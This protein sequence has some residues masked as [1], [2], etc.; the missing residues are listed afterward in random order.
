MHGRHDRLPGI[1]IYLVVFF[2]VDFRERTVVVD[3]SVPPLTVSQIIDRDGLEVADASVELDYRHVSATAA[4]R[5]L[6]P[7]IPEVPSSFEQ[8]GH[9]AHLNLRDELRPYRF[10]IGTVLLDK[11]PKLKTVVNKIGSI[12]NEWRVFSMELLAGKDD[13]IAEVRQHGA[14]FR[15]DFKKVYWNSRLEA[16]HLRLVE[17]W[18]KEGEVVAD[19]M[20]GIGP[21]AIPAG[22]RGCRVLANDLNPDSYKWLVENIKINKV[23]GAVTAYN[24]DGR[25]FLRRV[26]QGNLQLP[27]TTTSAVK[28]S[29]ADQ[30]CS[31]APPCDHVVMNLPAAAVEFLDALPGAFNLDLWAERKLPMVHV[32]A[33]LKA[34]EGV[35][36]EDFLFDCATYC[37][38]RHLLHFE[39]KSQK[40]CLSCRFTKANRDCSWCAIRKIPRISFSK[41]R[42][43]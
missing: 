41:G 24:L 13:M 40:K 23:A 11:N 27:E 35:V 21:F 28:D 19:A 33:F 10:I 2:Y 20:S 22:R 8:I 12:E 9:I 38:T 37:C 7:D 32:Y 5:R 1:I 42:G 39:L 4:L 26:S 18:F 3:S 6:I 15:L 29:A 17:R 36:G 14:R 31:C 43:S 34:D 16:E 30:A 25:D